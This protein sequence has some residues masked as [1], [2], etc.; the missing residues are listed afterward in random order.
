MRRGV[1]AVVAVL[2]VLTTIV[3]AR[4]LAHS[5]RAE[6]TAPSAVPEI[7]VDGAAAVA[8]LA[9][10]LTFETISFGGDAPV[11]SEAFR[12]FQEH[13]A[14]SYPRVHA[15]LEREAIATHS[16]LFTWKG[17]E[18]ALAP[19][20]LMAHQD[21]VPVDAAVWQE[22]PFAGRIAGGEL[23]GRGAIDD[24]GALFAILEAVERLLADGWTPRRSLLL[25]FGHDEETG[26][27]GAIA[28]A[29]LLDARGIRPA[30]VLDEGG[31]VVSGLIPGVER[32]IALI[33]IAEKG[34][35]TLQLDL[36]TEGGH[37]S[38]PPRHTAIGIMAEAIHHLETNPLPG[39]ID[40]ATQETLQALAPELPF[41][42]RAAISNLWLFGSLVEA[43]LAG[44]PALDA[45]QRTTTAVTMIEGGVKS[46]VLPSHVRATVNFRIRPGDS[47]EQVREHVRETIDDERIEITLAGGREPSE[48]SPTDSE[49]YALLAST[50]VETFPDAAV[51]PYVMVAGTDSRHFY[52]VTPNVYRFNPFRFRPETVTLP[53]GTDERLAVDGIPDAIRFYVR[54]I[55]NSDGG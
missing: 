16:L 27:T 43:V 10:G 6:G 52:A 44:D 37:S 9:R 49:G 15:V 36:E 4:T 46:N 20:L 39:R 3:V 13:L 47:I 33:G 29:G 45:L 7:P 12:A 48:V 51:V 42:V 22:P 55:R 38:V 30:F 17:S 26:G 5:R 24:K 11:Q 14:T 35:A 31:F 32:P 23:W 34:S 2:L 54:L 19:G 41:P 18:P 53:H 1:S 50:I 8:R 40:G 25:F 21:V 28:A